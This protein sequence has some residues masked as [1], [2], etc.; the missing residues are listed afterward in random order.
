MGKN[1]QTFSESFWVFDWNFGQNE[2]SVLVDVFEYINTFKLQSITEN[3]ISKH[4]VQNWEPFPLTWCKIFEFTISIQIWSNHWFID[5]SDA[6]LL[7][8]K[9]IKSQVERIFE[10]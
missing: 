5:V 10:H 9:L 6:I 8:R 3:C 4:S 1:N 7:H 2:T